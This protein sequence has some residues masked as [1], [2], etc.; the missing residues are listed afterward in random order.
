MAVTVGAVHA[1]PLRCLLRAASTF[2]GHGTPASFNARAIPATAEPT[3][4]WAKI[5]CT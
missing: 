2:D 5:H 4:R 1:S 3:L